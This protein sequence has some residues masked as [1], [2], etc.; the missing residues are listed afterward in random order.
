MN[1]EVYG[2]IEVSKNSGKY[3]LFVQG[4]AVVLSDLQRS[5]HVMHKIIWHTHPNIL[6][7]WFSA[8]DVL[9]P[10]RKVEHVEPFTLASTNLSSIIFS[11]QGIWEIDVKQ[12]VHLTDKQY[13][14]LR[15]KMN[16]ELKEFHDPKKRE[17][18]ILIN[19]ITKIANS[20]FLPP[21]NLEIYFTNWRHR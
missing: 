2:H 10:L 5:D 9:S 15:D 13:E 11:S 12:A 1:R 3:Y 7:W 8:E 18:K 20:D 14:F 21:N 6:P 17:P 16:V 19:K 4:L